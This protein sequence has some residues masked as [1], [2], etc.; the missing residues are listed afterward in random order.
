MPLLLTVDGLPVEVENGASVLDAVNRAG[1]YL[2]QLCKDPERPRLGT[3]RTCLVSIEGIPGAPAACAAPA[4]EG[5]VVHTTA[6]EVDRIRRGALQLTLDML[7][8]TDVS[9]LG[10]LSTAIARYGLQRGRF[11]PEPPV[12]ARQQ[13]DESDPFWLL[14]HARCILCERCVMACQEVQHIYALALLDRSRHTTVGTF[15]HGPI[16]AS[17]CTTCG[18]CWATCPTLAIRLKRP[19]AAWSAG[20]AP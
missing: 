20:D 6:P 2:P 3:C 5:M 10:E 1:V 9:R 16:R 7:P 11:V 18:Q 14:D 17:N 4:R 19:L 15:R 12:A 8:E 13:V